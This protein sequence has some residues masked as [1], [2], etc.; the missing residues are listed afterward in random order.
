MIMRRIKKREW[1]TVNHELQL[2]EQREQREQR[3][4]KLAQAFAAVPAK[5]PWGEPE[6]IRE[7]SYAMQSTTDTD[8]VLNWTIAGTTLR[9]P[10]PTPGYPLGFSKWLFVRVYDL[11]KLPSNSWH[12]YARQ[13]DVVCFTC[14]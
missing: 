4:Q 7:A 10:K 12:E 2:E 9:M 1:S 14:G 8:T 3:R 13:E 5:R 6:I 11:D